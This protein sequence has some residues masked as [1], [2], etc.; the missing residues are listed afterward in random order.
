M[1]LRKCTACGT[2]NRGLYHCRVC[3]TSLGSI[4]DITAETYFIEESETEPMHQKLEQIRENMPPMPDRTIINTNWTWHKK[5]TVWHK[6]MTFTEK[7]LIYRNMD[8][9]YP[10]SAFNPNH[11]LE[12]FNKLSLKEGYFLDYRYYESDEDSLGGSPDVFARKVGSIPLPLAHNEENA[13]KYDVSDVVEYEKSFSGLLQLVVFFAVYNTFYL[14]WHSQ[15]GDNRPVLSRE[16]YENLLKEYSDKLSITAVELLRRQDI[17]P[18][19]VST[20]FLNGQV[21]MMLFNRFSG[22]KWIRYTIENGRIINSEDEKIAW[23]KQ[24][25]RF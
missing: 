12:A 11:Y 24:R 25:M 17:S 5:R 20:D 6:K 16:Y 14:F 21:S 9:S 15:Y 4:T 8:K 10:E 13:E 7:L 22:F 19:I 3:G 23:I 2:D 18:R 1:F